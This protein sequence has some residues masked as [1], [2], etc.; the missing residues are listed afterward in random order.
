MILVVDPL[1]VASARPQCVN[2]VDST[3]E[4]VWMGGCHWKSQHQVV[5][6]VEV[7]V[8]FFSASCAPHQ[9]TACALTSAAT[10]HRI[11]VRT[12]AR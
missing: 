2:P 7:L 10:N 6:P 8:V 12:S 5:D 4:V 11:M 1:V 9:P 3:V